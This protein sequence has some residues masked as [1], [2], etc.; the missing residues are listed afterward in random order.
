MSPAFARRMQGG[1]FSSHTFD[2]S[3]AGH[4]EVKPKYGAVS[5]KGDTSRLSRSN[6]FQ[7]RQLTWVH[8]AEQA[9]AQP[10]SWASPG[11][12]GKSQVLAP[13]PRPLNQCVE[14]AAGS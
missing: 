7:L 8:V 9:T 5:L 14:K 6:G 13:H 3:Q 11:A 4:E 12:F 2:Y 10:P 1:S